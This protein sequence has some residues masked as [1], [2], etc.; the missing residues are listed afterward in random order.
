MKNT[1]L[2]LSLFSSLSVI[3][4]TSGTTKPVSNSDL[5]TNASQSNN[6]NSGVNPAGNPGT[7]ISATANSNSSNQGLIQPVGVPPAPAYY[8]LPNDTIPLRTRVSTDAD[9]VLNA[10]T[11]TTQAF[12]PGDSILPEPDMTPADAPIIADT[13][14]IVTSGIAPEN[15]VAPTGISGTSRSWEYPAIQKQR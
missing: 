1:L 11:L 7:I 8:N 13:Q 15:N 6:S 4:Q 12:V 3:G 10:D 14:N 9:M 5:P 2:V